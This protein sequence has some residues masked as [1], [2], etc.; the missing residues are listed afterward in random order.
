MKRLSV[1]VDVDDVL[2]PFAQ[3]VINCYNEE[4]G[5]NMKLEDI[6]GW[7]FIKHAPEI[8]DFETFVSKYRG[9]LLILS[10]PYNLARDFMVRLRDRGYR[11]TIATNQF[12]SVQGCTYTWLEKNDI[13]YDNLFFGKDK[14]LIRGDIMLDDKFRNLQKFKVRNRGSLALLMDKPWNREVPPTYTD[15]SGIKEYINLVRVKD[16]S[17]AYKHIRRYAFNSE[18]EKTS[19]RG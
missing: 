17:D 9:E 18:Y 16:L 19:K 12:K 13:P 15:D 5:K 4:Y 1:V 14:Y 2:R 8:K 7:E 6:V 10:K 11:V 3:N